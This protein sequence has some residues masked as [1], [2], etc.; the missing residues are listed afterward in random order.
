[1][2]DGLGQLLALKLTAL[3]GGRGVV[4]YKLLLLLLPKGRWYYFHM[5]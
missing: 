4:F 1:M 5:K 2:V 3:R